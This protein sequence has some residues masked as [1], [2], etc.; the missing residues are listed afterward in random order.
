MAQV[1]PPLQQIL[2]VAGGLMTA[3]GD[4]MTAAGVEVGIKVTSMKLR[5][6]I[7]CQADLIGR[8]KSEYYKAC[9]I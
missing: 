9:Y 4:L 6:I 1:Q 8:N 5:G 3:A 7:Q 2:P